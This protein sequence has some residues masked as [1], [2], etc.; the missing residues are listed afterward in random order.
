MSR[1]VVSTP[2]YRINSSMTM[3]TVIC[4][5]PG[6][7]ALAERAI[8]DA[9]PDDVQIRI[10]RVGELLVLLNLGHTWLAERWQADIR[11]PGENVLH[12]MRDPLLRADLE[13]LLRD[14]VLPVFDA[15]GQ[16]S[17]AR[18]YLDDVRERFENPFLDHRL[19][20]IARNHE[21][22]KER[23]FKPLIELARE[24]G[25]RVEQPRL[26]AALAAC[27]HSA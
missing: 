1:P 20:D 5:Q 18:A 26:S 19:A 4:E 7:L 2:R 3:K 17:E 25:V 9:G 16:G 15:L 13:S 6:Q 22:K 21:Q 12:A 14:E 11:D 27:T 23:R 24:P 10:R 8:P